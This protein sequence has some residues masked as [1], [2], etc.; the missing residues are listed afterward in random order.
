MRSQIDL[1]SFI[2]WRKLKTPKRHFE[3]NWLLARAG[4]LVTALIVE[5]SLPVAG[6]LWASWAFF[7]YF[8]G[9][10]LAGLSE[11]ARTF[12]RFGFGWFALSSR[13]LSKTTFG[14]RCCRCC[15]ALFSC[16]HRSEKKT[17]TVFC[18]DL[19]K[20]CNVLP[21]SCTHLAWRPS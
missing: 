13:V 18:K 1:F 14:R 2:F 21:F 12:H 20:T 10:C 15:I 19:F 5:T 8:F 3:I 17:I 4:R 11:V 6:Q 7:S 9:A 16:R